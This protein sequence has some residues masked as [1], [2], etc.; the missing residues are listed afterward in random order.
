MGLQR[1]ARRLEEV[2]H[3]TEG[4]SKGRQAKARNRVE[5]CERRIAFDCLFDFFFFFCTVQN[6]DDCFYFDF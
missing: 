6:V 4:V 1:G 3:R 5:D 2:G